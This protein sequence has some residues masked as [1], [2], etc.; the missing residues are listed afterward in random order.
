M[1]NGEPI[2]LVAF[3]VLAAGGWL[4]LT[5]L[6]GVVSGWFRLQR[7]YKGPQERELRTLPA[8]SG[9]M[10][11]IEFRGCLVLAACPS[12]LR[13]AV[14]PLFGPFEKPFIVP[15]TEIRAQNVPA[16]FGAKVQLMFGDGIGSMRIKASSW[17]SLVAC[18][19]AS[20]ISD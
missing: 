16:L 9:W 1:F 5:S 2:S 3:I 13:V 4:A 14:W 20:S 8:E 15:W 19:N 11:G 18:V 10:G 17:E 7:H 6:L 12:G